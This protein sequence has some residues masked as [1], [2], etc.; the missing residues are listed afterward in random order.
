MSVI[1]VTGGTS[2]IGL[3][4][5]V[6]LAADGHRV[7]AASRHPDRA[8]LPDGVTALMLDVTDPAAAE[9][10][11]TGIVGAAGRLDA[12]VNNAGIS[13]G[14]PIEETGDVDVL[15]VFET[16]LFGP[17]RLARA[18]VP[19]M[20][21]QGGGRIVNVTSMNDV[22]AAPFGGWYSASKA[23]LAS[24]SVVLGAEVHGFGIR[25]SVVAP[26]LFHT[27][28]AAALGADPVD[29]AS[30]YRAALTALQAA[31]ADRLAGAGDPADVAAA[32]AG[33]IEAAEPPARVVVGDDARSFEK[34]VREATAD[35][36]AA[37]LRDYVAQLDAAG[38]APA[39]PRPG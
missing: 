31:N 26:G 34:L 15:R 36:Y 5:V 13:E 14:G 8:E 10:A 39:E 30:R 27:P 11:V 2:G 20:R 1:L 9:P 6:R 3:A 16:N 28:M 19:V 35:D 22:V 17:M 32:I 24:A 23:A 21:S 4:T 38:P 33:C 29:P 18:A 25:V 12:L 7:F 37:M